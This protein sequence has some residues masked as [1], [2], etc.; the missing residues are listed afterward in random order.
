[1]ASIFLMLQWSCVPT[2]ENIPTIKNGVIDI[3][4]WD[5]TQNP[6]I[7]LQ[8]TGLFYWKQWPLDDNGNYAPHYLKTADSIGW[9]YVVSSKKQDNP[10]G[11]GTYRLRI[12]KQVSEKKS[13]IH[14]ERALAGVEVW[15]NGKKTVTHGKISKDASTEKIDGRPLIIELPNEPTLD[16]MFLFSNHKHRLGGGFS[17]KNSLQEHTYFIQKSKKAALIEGIITFL[18]LLFGIYQIIHY[19]S[20]PKYKY[21]LYLGLFCIIGASRQLFI[22]EGMIYNFFPNISFDFVQKMRYIGYYGGLASVFMY[23]MTLFPGYLSSR[24]IKIIVT[25]PIIGSLYVMIMPVYYGTYSAPFFQFFGLLVILIGFYQILRAIK[26]K[27]PY[28]IGIF[29]SMS[30]TCAVFAN[31]LLN[32]MLVIQTAF[33]VNYGLLLYVGFQIILNNKIQRKTEKEMLRLSVDIAKM[34][35]RIDK[36]EKEITELRSETF[37]QLKSKEKLVENL[38]KVA[39]ND[40]SVSIQNVIAS[41]KSELLEDTQLTRI[42]NDIE[43][44]NHEFAQRIKTLHPNLTKTDIEICSYLRLSLDRKEI[45]KLRFTSID[46][47]KKSRYR[48]RKKINLSPEDDLDAYIKEI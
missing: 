28:A 6:E 1:M 39:S 17:M 32:A 26:D 7:Q 8:G 46:A 3:T 47:V 27:K 21:F 15:I 44:L 23:H 31:D 11:F 16:I 24:L 45:A 48:L 25:I 19:F 38:K 41:L 42:K 5:V 14:I 2:D 33:V 29:I 9:P 30:L 34:A 10:R 37:Q 18:I 4:T 22:G 36:K 40:T 20:F 43:T 12:Q 35:D 13:I